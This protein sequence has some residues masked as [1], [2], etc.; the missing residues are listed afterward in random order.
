MKKTIK[1]DVCEKEF[2][3]SSWATKDKRMHSEAK[4]FKC[5]ICEN[6]FALSSSFSKHK[7]MHTAA[8]C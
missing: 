8:F 2:T 6:E 3:G 4:P 7:R 1:C 5:E